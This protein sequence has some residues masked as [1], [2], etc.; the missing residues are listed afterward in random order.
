MYGDHGWRQPGKFA[1]V[2]LHET[3]VS[4][5]RKRAE[6]SRVRVPW[7]ETVSEFTVRMKGIA[8][9]INATHDVDGL[10]RQLPSILQ[11]AVDRGGDR[12]KY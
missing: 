11:G 1:D 9:D 3:A 6:K 12:L 10:C 5:I 4:W 2:L 8:R 7:A